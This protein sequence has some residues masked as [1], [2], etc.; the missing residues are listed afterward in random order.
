LDGGTFR[1]T[2]DGTMSISGGALMFGG[3]DQKQGQQIDI[4]LTN[5]GRLENDGQ[6]WFGSD[7]ENA[8]G[9]QVTMTINNG[10]VDLTGGNSYPL[11]LNSIGVNP[12][13]AFIYDYR[14]A[15]DSQGPLGPAG[16]KYVINFTG[17][18]SITV[19]RAGIYVVNENDGSGSNYSFD[20]KTYQE[21]WALGILQA[22]GLSGLTGAAF[23][24]YFTASG[25]LGSDNYTLMSRQGDVGP[26]GGPGDYNNDGAVDAADYVTWRK[27]LGQFVTLPNDLTPGVVGQPDY[28]VWQTNFGRTAGSGGALSAAVPEPTS[29]VLLT[30]GLALGL[31][32]RRP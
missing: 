8:A 29:L 10:S 24:D 13:L 11:G 12:D 16:E 30:L 28:D 14:A 4:T 27:N 18:G 19:D 5:G 3:Y 25:S 31:L 2:K 7:S 23:G 6:L 21:L 22:N 20:D 32:R 9:L 26:S 15:T 17:P 1:R